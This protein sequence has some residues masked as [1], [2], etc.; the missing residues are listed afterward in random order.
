MTSNPPTDESEPRWQ[1]PSFTPDADP[2]YTQPVT[3]RVIVPGATGR[4]PPPSG[5]ETVIGTLAKL[6]W[7]VAIMAII[8][9]HLTFWPVLIVAI[10]LGT[11]LSALKNNLRQRRRAI[12]QQPGNPSSG[13]TFR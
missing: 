6:V 2:Q 9:T 5:F 10:V 11:V 13:P 12:A 7:P 4:V 3:G 8:F 1:Q